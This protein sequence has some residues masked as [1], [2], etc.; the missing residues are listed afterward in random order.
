[1]AIAVDDQGIGIEP[2]EQAAIFQHFYQTRPG[3]TGRRGAGV[4]LN[5]ARR[6]TQLQGGRMWLESTVDVGSTFWFALPR[7]HPATT[8]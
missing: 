4:G 8:T 5:I 6:Y 7:A 3:L 2:G 1:M